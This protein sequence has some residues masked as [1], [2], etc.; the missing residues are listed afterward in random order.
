MLGPT[1]WAVSDLHAA[2]KAN[3]AKIDLIQPRH[4]GGL[5]D[6]RG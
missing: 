5:A 3:Q 1:L 4:E 6:C 2:V